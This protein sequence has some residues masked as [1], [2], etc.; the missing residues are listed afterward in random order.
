M[1]RHFCKDVIYRI[2]NNSKLCYTH[3]DLY[4]VIH[5]YALRLKRELLKQVAVNKH[6]VT[7][8]DSLAF[9]NCSRDARSIRQ[10]HIKYRSYFR[11]HGHVFAHAHTILGV[12]HQTV[13]LDL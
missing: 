7:F 5:A 9:F 2:S 12:D 11:I 4:G 3:Q 13:V 10:R 8:A 6:G 1:R